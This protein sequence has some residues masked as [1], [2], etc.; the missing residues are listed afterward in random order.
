MVARSHRHSEHIL[1]ND[2]EH[3]FYTSVMMNSVNRVTHF[4][5]LEDEAISDN[6]CKKTAHDI[7]GP[8]NSLRLWKLSRLFT[9]WGTRRLL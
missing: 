5:S 6:G 4:S 2:G 3:Y 7:H 8:L 9:K 1:L